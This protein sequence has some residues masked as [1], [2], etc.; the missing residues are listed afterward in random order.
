MKTGNGLGDGT[1]ADVYMKLNGDK[2]S[3]NFELITEGGMIAD[4]NESGS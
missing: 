2:G 1:D 3:T 4:E